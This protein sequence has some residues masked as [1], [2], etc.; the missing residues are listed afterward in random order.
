M[1][2]ERILQHLRGLIKVFLPDGNDVFFRYWDGTWFAEQLRFMG[3]DWREVMPPFAFYF[4]NGEDFTVHITGQGEPK[5]SPWWQ[6][7]QAL[8]DAMMQKDNTPLVD[9][10]LRK[11][12]NNHAGLCERFPETVLRQKITTRL[13]STPQNVP[14]LMTELV[15]S[16]QQESTA[17]AQPFEFA[18]T[19]S[20]R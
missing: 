1:P 3:D 20:G 13:R 11:L 12:S 6:V 7:P 18:N 15:A 2:S 16:L 5:A 17:M 8:I 9:S 14:A 19:S 4:V 10:I